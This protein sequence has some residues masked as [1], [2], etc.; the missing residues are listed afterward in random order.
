MQRAETFRAEVGRDRAFEPRPRAFDRIELGGIGGQA[1][2]REPAL[3]ALGEG[4]RREAAVRIDAVPDHDQGTAVM[5]VEL[6][7]K[8]DDVLGAHRSGHQAEKEPGPPSMRRVG[9]GT[10]AREILPVA[11]AVG[12][13][14]RLAPRR[15]SPL[16]RRPLREAA[17]V[18]EDDRGPLA[19]GVFFSAGHVVF[20]QRSIAASSR[21]RAR[22]VGF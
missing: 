21:S 6:L 17:L 10:D 8:A 5:A 2:Q 9:H 16:D 12:Q 11:E 19:C 1:H 18:E 3:L 14:R 13:D 7:E 15:P 22:V 4:T 20:T